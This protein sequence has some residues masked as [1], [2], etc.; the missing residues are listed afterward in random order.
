MKAGKSRDLQDK[1]ASWRPRRAEGLVPICFLSP[2]TK[3]ADVVPGGRR[4]GRAKLSVQFW[5]QEKSN[6][7]V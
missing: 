7:P 5:G 3:R 1:S 6:V 2:E 4:A